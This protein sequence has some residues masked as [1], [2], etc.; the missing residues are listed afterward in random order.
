M[1]ISRQLKQPVHEPVPIVDIGVTGGGFTCFATTLA[2]EITFYNLTDI[3]TSLPDRMRRILVEYVRG[4]VTCRRK[5]Q[6]AE[7]LDV[8]FL[9]SFKEQNLLNYLQ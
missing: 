9:K 8:Y 4:I 6:G 3:L 7:M 2:P 5:C 1:A